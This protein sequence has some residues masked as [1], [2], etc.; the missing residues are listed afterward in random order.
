MQASGRSLVAERTSALRWHTC[1]EIHAHWLD[2]ADAVRTLACSLPGERQV[3]AKVDRQRDAR[4]IVC[5]IC[6]VDNVGVC[7]EQP[8]CAFDSC[9]QFDRAHPWRSGCPPT[10]PL[11]TVI[12]ALLR[13]AF[14]R[15]PSVVIST[16]ITPG[17]S[18]LGY[19][20]VQR[21]VPFTF[22]VMLS[23]SRLARTQGG[24]LSSSVI[25]LLLAIMFAPVRA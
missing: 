10:A 16:S 14:S 7:C 11:P 1:W 23:Y 25:G 20:P 17:L 22:L 12:V 21:N 2:G 15:G 24:S 13:F 3:R 9:S 6:D 19:S 4:A 8:S 18:A 5:L